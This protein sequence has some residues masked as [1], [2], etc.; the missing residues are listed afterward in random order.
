MARTGSM[1][2]IPLVNTR[3]NA[4]LESRHKWTT[5]TRLTASDAVGCVGLNIAA[6]FGDVR[7]DLEEELDVDAVAIGKHLARVVVDVEGRE[8]PVATVEVPGLDV[9]PVVLYHRDGRPGHH[10]NSFVVVY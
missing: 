10:W 2:V 5:G 4:S 3:H 1:T 8:T 6:V 7:I 9:L